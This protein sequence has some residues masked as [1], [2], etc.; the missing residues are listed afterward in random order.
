MALAWAFAK[1][2]ISAVNQAVWAVMPSMLSVNPELYGE[3]YLRRL[4]ADC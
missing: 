1:C 4:T 3:L 2:G